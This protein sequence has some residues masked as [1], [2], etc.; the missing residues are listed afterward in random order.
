[1]LISLTTTGSN[2]KKPRT[3]LSSRPSHTTLDSSSTL[4]STKMSYLWVVAHRSGHASTELTVMATPTPKSPR[5]THPRNDAGRVK[6]QQST[7]IRFIKYAF[8]GPGGGGDGLAFFSEVS[9]FAFGA[10]FCAAG[11]DTKFQAVLVM[12]RAMA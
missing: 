7:M 2:P 1:M 10:S 8:D 5:G 6:S 11:P 3:L 4:N 9:V 12:D